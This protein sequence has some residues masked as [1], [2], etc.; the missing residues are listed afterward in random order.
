MPEDS[1]TLCLSLCWLSDRFRCC[2]RALIPSLTS[3]LK[4]IVE[5]RLPKSYDYHRF[6]APFIQ[7]CF[8]RGF[9]MLW[10]WGGGQQRRPIQ[11]TSPAAQHPSGV[12]LGGG[13]NVGVGGGGGAQAAQVVRLPPLPS[14]LHPGEELGKLKVIW[15]GSKLVHGLAHALCARAGRGRKNLCL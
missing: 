4:Q 7:V 14:T 5:H 2:S 11:L 12:D 9:G 8:K 10:E 3:I 13:V 6:P 1:Q 15:K